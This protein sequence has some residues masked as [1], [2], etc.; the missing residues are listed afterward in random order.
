MTTAKAWMTWAGWMTFK[1][2]SERDKMPE[3]MTDPD[4]RESILQAFYE[5]YRQAGLHVIVNASWVAQK[6]G[7]DGAQARRCFDYLSAK[8]LVRPVTVGGGYSPTVELVD[9]V[10]HDGHGNYS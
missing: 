2:G 10:E 8:G 9:H 6:L 7:L 5:Q 1:T 4:A 3:T